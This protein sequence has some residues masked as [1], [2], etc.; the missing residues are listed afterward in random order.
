[1]R[2]IGEPKIIPATKTNEI[3]AG[4]LGT[5]IYQSAL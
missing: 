4:L 3:V 1:M 5:R 2:I